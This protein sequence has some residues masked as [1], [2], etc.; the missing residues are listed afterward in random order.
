MI[1]PTSGLSVSTHTS[2][3][4][5]IKSFENNWPFRLIK[6]LNLDTSSCII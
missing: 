2:T 3:T 4:T 1:K 5:L 6:V